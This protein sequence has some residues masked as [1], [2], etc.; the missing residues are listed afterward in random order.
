MPYVF[1][2]YNLG[3][4]VQYI[5]VQL[6]YSHTATTVTTL[7]HLCTVTLTCHLAV[8]HKGFQR[9]TKVWIDGVVP[10]P[11]LPIESVGL[12]GLPVH[13]WGH[14]QGQGKRLTSWHIL[15]SVSFLLSLVIYHHRLCCFF[16]AWELTVVTD[17]SFVSCIF[18]HTQEVIPRLDASTLM[19]T[20]V[21]RTP[22]GRQNLLWSW[23]TFSPSD[24]LKKKLPKGV[25][26][27][28]TESF[29]LSYFLSG[30][31]GPTSS[32]LTEH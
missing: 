28:Q 15:S 2:L 9:S 14:D 17:F 24:W 6:K 22:V 20:R 26:G 23:R 11:V 29:I 1:T 8:D 10:W 31:M 32:A 12:T 4:I 13:S 21:W 3:K 27:N 16:Y 7:D 18:T 19:L 5:L 30:H 25:S